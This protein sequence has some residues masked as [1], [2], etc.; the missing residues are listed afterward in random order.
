MNQ[1]PHESTIKQVWLRAG[2]P[3]LVTW[4]LIPVTF[5]IPRIDSTREPFFDLTNTLSQLAYWV[6]Q[7]GG[8]FGAPIVAVLTLS[9]LVTRRGITLRRR[10]REAGIVVLVAA[11]F[12]G[13]GTALTVYVLKGQLKVPRPNIVWLA[14]ESDSGVLGMTPEGFYDTGNKAARRRPLTEAL[15][16][17]PQPV[18]MSSS[19]QSHWIE[20]T[21]YSFPSGH[22]YAAMFF[23]TFLGLIGATYLS[24]TRLWIFYTLLP[25]ALAVCY[26]RSILRVHTPIDITVGGLLG[27][28]VGFLAWA[29]ARSLIRRFG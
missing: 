18:P 2:V 7:S 24:A 25:W 3:A 13:G 15:S 4:L 8:R 22:A 23:A 6:S 17:V 26:S 5:L 12:G 20:E 19:I 1:P 21:G 10:L 11:I 29:A 28:A 14:E 16:K 27:L 9:L